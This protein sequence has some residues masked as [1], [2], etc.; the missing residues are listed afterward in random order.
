MRRFFL[1]DSFTTSNSVGMEVSKSEGVKAIRRD[2][3]LDDNND[4][5]K[6]KIQ[7]ERLLEI[8][9]KKGF[10]VVQAHPRKNTIT[11]LK[12]TLPGNNKVEIVPLSELI[13]RK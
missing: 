9:A 6:I 4:P 5:A 3:F 11:F 12:K 2:V 8:A 13:D 7:W 10:A 1:L